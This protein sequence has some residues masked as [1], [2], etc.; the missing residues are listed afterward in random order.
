[1]FRTFISFSVCELQE[2]R[3]IIWA[4]SVEHDFISYVLF[5]FFFFTL[6]FFFVVVDVDVVDMYSRWPQS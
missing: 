1:M 5:F 3:D 2:I 4:T 6:V